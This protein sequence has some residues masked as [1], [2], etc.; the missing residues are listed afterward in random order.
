M[1]TFGNIDGIKIGQIFN[2]RED[3]SKS[4]IHAPYMGEFGEIK[5]KVHVLLSYLEDMRMMKMS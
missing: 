1:L 2:S 5:V 3:L 4:G